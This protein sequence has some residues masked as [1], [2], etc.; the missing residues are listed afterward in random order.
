[1]Q[2]RAHETINEVLDMKFY[3]KLLPHD[4]SSIER[5]NGGEHWGDQWTMRIRNHF[6]SE[7]DQTEERR[8]EE[9][10]SSLRGEEGRNQF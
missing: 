8:K 1:M 7:E 5:S 2:F 4:H 9:K 10:I 6:G 3:S